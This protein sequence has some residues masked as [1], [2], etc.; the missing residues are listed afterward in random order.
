MWSV[1]RPRRSKE[2][3]SSNLGGSVKPFRR[4]TRLGGLA[5]MS[6]AVIEM[7][8]TIFD[9]DL[10]ASPDALQNPSWVPSHLAFSVAYTLV[11]PG[12]VALY[13]RQADRLRWWGEAGFVLALFGSTLTVSI[14]MLVGA[15]LP[16]IA[17]QSPGLTRSLPF[18]EP[19]R[20]LYF[21]QP[22]V[23]LTALT[24][25]PG[26]VLTGIATLRARVLSP[27]AARFIVLGALGTL[28]ALAGAGTVARLITISGA[29]FLGIAFGWLGYELVVATS[30][31]ARELAF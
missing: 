22:A 1:R 27:W 8:A 23:V 13:L 24:Y 28:G 11:L 10:M 18:F 30:R 19:G 4:M 9:P 31:P 21:M 7:P 2:K 14:S 17:P 15:A 3:I 5:L 16:L 26:Y 6:A 29:A 12:L 25:F 20:P